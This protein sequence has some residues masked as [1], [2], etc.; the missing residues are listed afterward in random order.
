MYLNLLKVYF[1]SACSSCRK[2]IKW[3]DSHQIQYEKIDILKEPPSESLIRMAINQ[4]GD[5]KYVFNTNGLSYRAIGAKRIKQM[6]EEQALKA[7]TS[8]PKLIKRPFLIKEDGTVLIGF[9]EDLW[10]DKILTI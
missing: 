9:K 4:L 2:A 5:R 8:D 10:S 1:Y 3:L 6:S 7:L